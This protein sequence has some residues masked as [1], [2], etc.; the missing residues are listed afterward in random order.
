MPRRTVCSPLSGS[1]RCAIIFCV[2][3]TALALAPVVRAQAPHFRLTVPVSVATVHPDV[4]QV[5]LSCSLKNA[6]HLTSYS[7]IGNAV[8]TL[9]LTGGGYSGTVVLEI[10]VNS[11]NIP[12]DVRGYVCDLQLRSSTTGQYM[13]AVSSYPVVVPGSAPA[14]WYR[15]ARGPSYT[16]PPGAPAR[17]PY[18]GV[19]P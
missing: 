18:H 3:G 13:N 14:D 12:A 2:V 16:P 11:Q 7:T 8:M 9:P 1:V 6:A 10:N 17:F 5:R 4:T 15:D 19:V